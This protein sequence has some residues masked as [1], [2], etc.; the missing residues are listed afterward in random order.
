MW[1]K[2]AQP[3][4]DAGKVVVLGVVQEQHP[5]RARLYRQWRQFKWPI[6]VD[7]LNRLDLKA[8]PIPVA[9]DESGIVRHKRIST[10]RFVDDFIN[11]KYSKTRVS[12]GH[13]RAKKPN[14]A[15]LGSKAKKADSA[16]AWRDYGD[17]CFLSGKADRLDAA[18]DAYEHAVKLDSEDGRAQFRLGVALRRR[19]ESPQRRP[20]DAQ[21]A[22]RQWGIALG[23]NPNQYIWRRRIQQY[24]PRL[25]KPYNFYFWVKQAREEIR[26]R[27]QEPI[28]LRVEPMGSELAPPQRDASN[29]EP[30]TARDP[31]PDGKIQRDES[32]LVSIEATVAPARVQPGRRVRVRTT[33]RLNEKTRPLWNNEVDGLQVSID[34]PDGV[35]LH[36]GRL[37][38]PDPPQPETRETRVL[39]FEIALGRDHSPGKLELSAYALYYVCEEE[40]GVCL[41]LRQDF[42]IELVVDPNAPRIQ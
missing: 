3:L 22:V 40:G 20:G 39:E 16:R 17:A 41:F 24:G 28:V 9:I 23:L 34:V 10:R 19:Y 29:G 4:V 13:N 26:V 6:L 5:D 30:V 37:R 1:Q 12:S 32:S 2:V 42:K 7:S 8:V 15:R 25:D 38:Y 14:I 27:G 11:Q 36:E 31:D 33:F 18:V 35:T 21:A